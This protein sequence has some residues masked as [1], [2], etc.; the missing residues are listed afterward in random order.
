M[1]HSRSAYCQCDN[2]SLYGEKCSSVYV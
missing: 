2:K 1:T